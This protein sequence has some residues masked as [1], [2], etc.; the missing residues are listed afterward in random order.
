MKV[1]LLN[2]NDNGH[3]GMKAVARGL[4]Y[5]LRRHEIVSLE[6]CECLIVN[7]EGTLHHYGGTWLLESL[8]LSQ[9]RGVK[10][11]LVNAV[12]QSTPPY[13]GY[14]LSHLDYFSV[15]EPLSL[16]NAI[17]CGGDPVLAPDLC[18]YDPL[19]VAG[20]SLGRMP[21]VVI[22]ETP[23]SIPPGAIFQAVEAWFGIDSGRLTF[24]TPLPDIVATLKAN[25]SIYI[26]GQHHG[27]YAAILAGVPFIALP[28]NSW[29]IEG[30]LQWFESITGILPPLVTAKDQFKPAVDFAQEYRE[31]FSQFSEW[32]T[33]EKS[34][35]ENLAL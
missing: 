8:K 5:I 34:C 20:R 4:R 11:F 17:E 24:K 33:K 26:T 3:A 16:H 30:L 32:M 29:K 23:Y 22:G 18:I 19:L 15:R 6:D 12:F 35:L 7:G 27:L 25:R 28:S 9:S 1:A 10:T 2:V 13:Y 21:S 31:A 14:T